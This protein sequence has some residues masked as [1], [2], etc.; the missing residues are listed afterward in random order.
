MKDNELSLSHAEEIAGEGK[1]ENI[2]KKLRGSDVFSLYCEKIKNDYNNRLLSKGFLATDTDWEMLSVLGLYDQNTLEHSIRTFEL[3][4]EVITRPFSEPFCGTIVFQNL[5][6]GSGVFLEQ[7]LRAALFHDIG[8]IIIPRDILRNTLDDEEVL[9]K[10]FPDQNLEK[11]NH[12]TKAILQTFSEKGIRPI[13]IV[14]VKEI[15]QK[16]KYTELFCSLKQHGFPETA[17]LKD[18]IR[19]H[20]PESK[21]ILESLGCQVEAELAGYHHNYKNEKHTYILRVL[22]MSFGLADLIRIADVTDALRSVRWYKKPL[23]DIDVLFFLAKDA[24]AGKINSHVAYL[25]IK[26]Q[27]EK[28]RVGGH[29]EDPVLWSEKEEIQGVESFLSRFD[30]GFLPTSTLTSSKTFH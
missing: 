3:A 13:D 12:T 1:Y 27:Y 9:V 18:I 28:L 29:K 25:W 14:P 2:I 19:L 24:E 26:D 10:M 22:G 6:Q 5:F 16:E 11:N 17:T 23:S 4:H 15:F 7:F 8:K 30:A 20:E 21:R